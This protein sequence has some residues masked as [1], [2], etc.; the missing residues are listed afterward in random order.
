MLK[1]ASKKPPRYKHYEQADSRA[2]CEGQGCY[3]GDEGESYLRGDY[4]RF[5]EVNGDE[6]L[7][8]DNFNEDLTRNVSVARQPYL[9]YREGSSGYLSRSQ[10]SSS[11]EGHWRLQGKKYSR[12]GHDREFPSP[13]DMT[14]KQVGM[15]RN[16]HQYEGQRSTDQGE[17]S[18][19]NPGYVENTLENRRQG[20]VN[21][22]PYQHQGLIIT[23]APN[24]SKGSGYNDLSPGG[25]SESSRSDI[26]RPEYNVHRQYFNGSRGHYH[27]HPF[28][29]ASYS[30][31][32]NGNYGL[33]STASMSIDSM[34]ASG[35]RSSKST[36]ELQD[37]DLITD[38]PHGTKRGLEVKPPMPHKQ[39]H[40]HIGRGTH[41]IGVCEG[42]AA[43]VRAGI[44]EGH[45]TSSLRK[46]PSGV[47]SG[48]HV[49]WDPGVV[50][51]EHK[52]TLIP[53]SELQPQVPSKKTRKKTSLRSLLNLPRFPLSDDETSDHWS[54]SSHGT[55]KSHP[56]SDN[57]GTLRK[58]LDSHSGQKKKSPMAT[59]QTVTTTT[60]ELASLRYRKDFQG[61]DLPES[62]RLRYLG[63]KNMPQL[64]VTKANEQN[65]FYLMNVDYDMPQQTSA[66]SYPIVHSGMDQSIYRTD[67]R[68]G[69]QS[70]DDSGNISINRSPVNSVRPFLINGQA[71]E[72]QDYDNFDE[73]D[74][75]S[76]DR[77]LPV[78]H[79]TSD[80]NSLYQGNISPRNLNE[81]KLYGMNIRQTTQAQP[82]VTFDTYVTY[83]RPTESSVTFDTF[84]THGR[85]FATS[86]PVP[87]GNLGYSHSVTGSQFPFMHSYGS[88]N[89]HGDV[90]RGFDV[91]SGQ[92]SPSVT[93]S[94]KYSVG[95]H[96][97]ASVPVV[98]DTVV[99]SGR[100]PT[101]QA[102]AQPAGVA[103]HMTS[104]VM[105]PDSHGINIQREQRIG[106]GP[107]ET[108]NKVYGKLSMSPTTFITYS[109]GWSPQLSPEMNT[110]RPVH[111]LQSQLPQS[112]SGIHVSKTPQYK[113]MCRYK[114]N[115]STDY[116]DDVFMSLGLGQT[117]EEAAITARRKL[118]YE[119]PS[120]AG[121]PVSY[122]IIE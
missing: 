86:T 111:V 119:G 24:Y 19:F 69:Y 65:E 91:T 57:R 61:S 101:M 50:N 42:S 120:A 7:D 83:G 70:G 40:V 18:Q 56:T 107:Y 21:R 88:S 64:N 10:G 22:N 80:V 117:P 3:Y 100:V 46:S 76:Y 8:Y 113:D 41:G 67:T 104:R 31:D 49:R 62:S 81:Q 96:G 28:P 58:F 92:A 71:R 5:D 16:G 11:P 30:T 99:S 27:E 106:S 122:I 54:S 95:S 43:P 20:D 59:S 84:V 15:L 74:K 115:E 78:S 87:N 32:S 48:H 110:Q 98:R 34:S 109:P 63:R 17:R 79:N 44:S 97:D 45:M 72:T 102:S 13:S 39:K 12:V 85:P 108:D 4:T 94:W 116:D 9:G 55:V 26:Q 37:Y 53:I 121:Q 6:M 29:T 60:S 82:K 38:L 35:D 93:Q 73:P 23:A 75:Q 2:L 14:E 1:F 103:K 68:G 105:S 89:K 51:S 25:Y 112:Q 33:D 77:N 66:I 90:R 114:E 47:K 36:S 52:H 118:Q